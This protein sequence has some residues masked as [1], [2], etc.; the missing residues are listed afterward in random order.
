VKH[1]S[2][3]S[4]AGIIDIDYGD[5]VT[6]AGLYYGITIIIVSLATAMTVLTLNIHHRGDHGVPV[7]RLIQQICFDRLLARVLC[8][9]PFVDTAVS[10]H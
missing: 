1:C 8:L 9:R 2:Y 6:M 5:G 3:G 10:S 4:L 7:P